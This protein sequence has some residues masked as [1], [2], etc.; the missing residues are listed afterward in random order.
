MNALSLLMALLLRVTALCLLALAGDL[1]EEV[2]SSLLCASDSRAETRIEATSRQQANNHE[3]TS[4]AHR[5]YIQ[6]ATKV[7]PNSLSVADHHGQFVTIR[8]NDDRARVETTAE[9]TPDT[10]CKRGG[11]E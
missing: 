4:K 6:R 1:G 11:C 10:R 5:T 9:V 7:H 8:D 2:R 3:S